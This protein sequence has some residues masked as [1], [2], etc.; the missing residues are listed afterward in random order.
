[1]RNWFL[2]YLQRHGRGSITQSFRMKL[3]YAQQTQSQANTHKKTWAGRD[4]TKVSGLW[5]PCTSPPSVSEWDVVRTHRSLTSVQMVEKERVV[6][7]WQIWPVFYPITDAFVSVT[8]P[9][10]RWTEGWEGADKVPLLRSPRLLV[11]LV[12]LFNCSYCSVSWKYIAK[13]SLS[14]FGTAGIDSKNDHGMFF[15]HISM[16]CE[17]MFCGL[18]QLLQPP[19]VKA[20]AGRI[21]QKSEWDRNTEQRRLMVYYL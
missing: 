10:L 3:V 4:K 11:F 2:M 13:V 6:D 18:V 14:K 1:M 19:S 15:T 20:R 16:V 12:Q 7:L 5:E 17:N 21:V 8:R 9:F